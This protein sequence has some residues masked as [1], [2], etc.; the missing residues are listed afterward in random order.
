MG[1]LKREYLRTLYGE[2]ALHEMARFKRA[3]DPACVLG[4]GNV[5]GEELCGAI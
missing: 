1:K 4:R 5:F 2:R 3:F